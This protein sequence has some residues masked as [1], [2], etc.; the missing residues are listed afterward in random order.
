MKFGLLILWRERWFVVR[1]R[2]MSAIK[3]A[4]ANT[5]EWWHLFFY[6]IVGILILYDKNILGL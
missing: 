5:Q 1:C 4:M 2:T 3:V 6:F